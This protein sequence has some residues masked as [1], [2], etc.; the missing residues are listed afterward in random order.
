[1]S[2][3]NLSHRS[4]CHLAKRKVLAGCTQRRSPMTTIK[5]LSAG[6]I[7]TAMLAAPAMARETHEAGRYVAGE[8]NTTTFPTA[9]H[10]D[11]H[12]DIPAQSAR[13]LPA[14][15]DGENCDVGDNA[16]IC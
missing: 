15:P 8:S 14:P 7:V 5:L 2:W 11:G 12:F 1:M 9:H 13:A 4:V 16:F 3:K 6:L 10:A